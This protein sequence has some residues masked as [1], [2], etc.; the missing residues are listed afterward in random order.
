VWVEWRGD[1]GAEEEFG[2]R[3]VTIGGA[4]EEGGEEDGV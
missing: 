3:E 1:G 2:G 4:V